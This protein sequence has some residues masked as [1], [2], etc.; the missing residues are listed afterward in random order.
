[1]LGELFKL[2]DDFAQLFHP[3]VVLLHCVFHGSVALGVV[4]TSVG[5]GCCK[6]AAGFVEGV[7][8]IAM[9]RHGIDDI[10]YFFSN[11][12]RFLRQF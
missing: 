1:M 10:R 3:C 2:G 8:R 6:F 9:L 4:V 5:A 11:D 7:E 12:L